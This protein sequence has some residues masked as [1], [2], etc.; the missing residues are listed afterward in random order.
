MNE[1]EISSSNL[2]IAGWLLAH[3]FKLDRLNQSGPTVF[4][5]FRDPQKIGRQV[6]DSY[7]SGATMCIRDFVQGLKEARDKMSEHKRQQRFQGIENEQAQ[8]ILGQ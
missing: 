4:F 7:Y 5:I 6:I 2:N 8:R 3:K 1:N